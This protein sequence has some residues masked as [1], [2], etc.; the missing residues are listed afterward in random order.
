MFCRATIT[1]GIGPHSSYLRHSQLCTFNFES[2]FFQCV[3]EF[4]F[5]MGFSLDI[6]CTYKSVL[7]IFLCEVD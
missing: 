4:Y 7:Y 5:Q 1:L 3:S 2:V 6:S